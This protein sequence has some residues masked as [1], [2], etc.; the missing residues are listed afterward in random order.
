MFRFLLLC[1]YRKDIA[2]AIFESSIVLFHEKNLNIIVKI[3]FLSLEFYIMIAQ[4][5]NNR[6][7]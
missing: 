1:L 6:L 5:V 7:I 4:I 2:V 3:K